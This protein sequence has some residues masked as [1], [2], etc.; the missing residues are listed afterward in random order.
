M[1]PKSKFTKEEIIQVALEIA[2]INGI[3][4]ITARALGERMGSSPKPI[5]NFF[6]NMK[7][8]QQE[9]IKSAKCLY[10]KY[11][12][13]GFN[14]TDMPTFKAVGMQYILFAIEE[15]KLFQILFMSEQLKKPS[16]FNVLPMID[17]QYSEILLSVQKNHDLDQKNAEKVYRHLWIYTHGIAVLSATNMC[18]FTPKEMGN[19]LTEVCASILKEIK[20]VS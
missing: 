3:D 2:R 8:V 18:V 14:Q 7:E 11:V 12:S 20:G 16:G 17:D 4:A 1:P 6:K 10:S 19:M 9:V 5:F 15:P 13:K